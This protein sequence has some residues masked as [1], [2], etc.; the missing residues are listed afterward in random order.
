MDPSTRA[1]C[2]RLGDG[3]EKLRRHGEIGDAGDIRRR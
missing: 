2:L 1:R 3:V